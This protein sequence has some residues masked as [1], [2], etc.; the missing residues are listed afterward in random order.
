MTD[1][2][3]AAPRTTAGATALVVAFCALVAAT[4]VLWL[5][6]AP[7]TDESARALGVGTGAIANLAAVN[8]LVFVLLAVSAGRWLDR[9]LVQALTAGAALTALG[10]VVRA[11]DVHSYGVVLGGQLMVSAGQPLV[12]GAT[13]VLAVRY[14][15]PAARTAA[16]SAASAAQFVGILVAA[17]VAGPVVDAVGLPGLLRAE[18]VA[19]LAVGVVF[20]VLVR[21]VPARGTPPA[22][23]APGAPGLLRDRLL[24]GLAVML[25]VG[26][27][28]FNA[29]A[30]WL[31]PVL[32]DLGRPGLAGPLIAGMT[33]AGIAGAASLPA[34]AATRDRR[35]VVLLAAA[36]ASA[37]GF[38]VAA[39]VPAG[40]AT[41]VLLV[42]LPLV[43][44]VLLAGL[45]V[46]L[47]WA[48]LHVGADRA[49]RATSLLLLA[50]NAGGVVLVLAVEVA[51][52]R[53][54]PTLLTLAL[55]SLPAVAAAWSLPRR[56]TSA[57][58]PR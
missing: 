28:V 43:G 31:D 4:Q 26:V 34:W 47:E 22:A 46:A 50:G 6:F 38:A 1:R 30:T 21:R 27:G 45:P 7:V 29:V 55:L 44:F 10:A 49:A 42:V 14:V 15:A 18:A 36:L 39:V 54:A 24:V 35:R 53:A 57:A 9:R 17:L 20:V 12:L 40:A 58:A 3:T 48:E 41:G 13:T 52:G 37:G 56:A 23:V 5:T 33:V 19:V 16:I 51:G 8:P 25:F 11:V 2:D 32:G